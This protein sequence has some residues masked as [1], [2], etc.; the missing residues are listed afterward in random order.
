MGGYSWYPQVIAQEGYEGLQQRMWGDLTRADIETLNR[1]NRIALAH[2]VEE[3]FPYVDTEV[4]KLAMRVSPQLKVTSAED[5][6]GKR[7]HREAAKRLG[8]A[9]QYADR[10]KDAAQH[11]TG[12]HDVLDVIAINNGFT[13]E[14]VKGVGYNSEEIS[15][16]KLASSTRYGYLYAEKEL[17]QTPEHV[18]FFLDWVACE[19]D[20]LNESEKS[21]IEGFLEKAGR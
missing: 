7:P 9:A 8:L 2:R 19:N 11:G 10:S 21:R 17:W 18:Q 14:L 15:E 1:E 4:V 20:L 3:V 5:K 6:I 13:P 16:E 12:I